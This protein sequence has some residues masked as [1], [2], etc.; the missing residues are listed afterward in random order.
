MICRRDNQPSFF[1]VMV[2]TALGVGFSPLAPGTM[3]ALLAV[4]VW[5]AVSLVVDFASLQ[6]ITI[7]LILLFTWLGVYSGN[8][9]E[10]CWGEDPSRVVIDEVVGMWIALL[11]VPSDY[12]LYALMA[13]VLFRIFDI[14]KPFGIRRM[15]RLGGGLGIM[16]DD[17]VAG[18]YSALVI[19]LLRLFG[20][21]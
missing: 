14:A 19:L 11:A 2:G 18:L 21:L 3:G 10:K 12:I 4:L 8:K 9:L 20:I 7:F 16:M 17:I 5:L 15:E 13:F 1:H 6:I